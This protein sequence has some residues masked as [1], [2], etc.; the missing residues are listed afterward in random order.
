MNLR[1]ATM[2][3]TAS[4]ILIA[5]F[6][7]SRA[8]SVP[9][10]H[11]TD[12]T[13]NTYYDPPHETQVKMRLSGSDASPMPGGLLD[14]KQ[15]RIETFSE[16]GKP[17]AIVRAPQCTYSPMEGL[18]S[19]SGHLELRTADGRMHTEGDGFLWQ[20]TDNSLTI[21]NNVHTVIKAGL[22]KMTSP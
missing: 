8:Q 5:W 21:S 2:V 17:E 14:I 9:A 20:Q 15:L 7:D 1:T 10:G 4:A 12:F 18:A 16:D 13:S 19:S 3:M 22:W 11:A 6:A